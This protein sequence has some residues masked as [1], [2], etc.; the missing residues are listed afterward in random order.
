MANTIKIDEFFDLDRL[1]DQQAEAIKLVND[2]ISKV[3]EAN[4][5]GNIKMTGDAKTITDATKA[6]NENEQATRKQKETIDKTT[7]AYIRQKQIDDELLKTKKL[8]T[9]ATNDQIGAYSRLKAQAELAT[10]SARDLAAQYGVNS[11]QAKDAALKANDLNTKLKT[12]DSTMNI[13]NKN[14]GNYSSGIEGMI[15][16]FK[17]LAI[18]GVAVAAVVKMIGFA[19]DI[20]K[21]AVATTETAM[22]EFQ[23]TMTGMDKAT[24]AFF[25]TIY[26]G[27][28]SNLLDNMAEAY[29][30]G[31]EYAET[32]D[33]IAHQ[34]A[35]N[36]ANLGLESKAIA[37]LEEKMK[38]K[39]LNDSERLQ[40]AKDLLILKK[41]Y[42]DNEITLSAKTL[43]AQLKLMKLDEQTARTYVTT[44][45]QNLGLRKQAENYN[46]LLDE[47]NKLLDSQ[48]QYQ[49]KANIVTS[50]GTVIVRT[51]QTKLINENKEALSKYSQEIIAFAD[52]IRKVESNSP[53]NVKLLVQAL[54]KRGQSEAALYNE[55]KR[56]VTQTHAL[57]QSIEDDRKKA[58]EAYIK[59]LEDKRK[60]EQEY[61]KDLKINRRETVYMTD[62]VKAQVDAYTDL[63]KKIDWAKRN[64]LEIPI[65]EYD[66][67]LIKATGKSIEELTAEYEKLFGSIKTGKGETFLEWWG[68]LTDPEKI[69]TI[70][71][72]VGQLSGALSDVQAA[73]DNANQQELNDYKVLQDEKTRI[74]NERLRLGFLSQEQYNAELSNLQLD[75][76]EKKR[77]LEEKEFKRK[78]AV[79]LAEAVIE[80]SLAV[81]KIY[82][83]GTGG[84]LLK[85]IQAGLIAIQLAAQIANITSQVPTYAKG[86]KD[87][88]AETAIVGEQGFEYISTDTGLFK[89]PNRATMTYLPAGASVIPHNKSVQIE[90]YL[91]APG[92]NGMK[93]KNSIENKELLNAINKLNSKPNTSIN[94]DKHGFAVM[95]AKGGAYVNFVNDHIRIKH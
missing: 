24:K 5:S 73:M 65:E 60:K 89:T 22:D 41:Q 53:E 37:E 66:V 19:W 6:I 47:R 72:W 36:A 70:K 57:E 87:G 61:F 51:D 38:N 11:K 79:A 10:K 86:R 32:M 16:K 26:E 95:V 43:D 54:T 81:I 20:Y 77:A 88:P 71:D 59:R 2:Y 90:H 3:G 76:D 85:T 12:I 39:T 23:F 4:K 7:E 58:H 35:A 13:H 56:I 55:N 80:S 68:G 69:D 21:K 92:V 17:G 34:T 40:A 94:I 91:Q 74:L 64:N 52:V 83:Q 67:E 75:Y 82:S 25:K 49:E 62:E 50:R 15:E 30:R 93:E 8:E 44:D 84:Y 31:H 48:K 33:L 28:W 42:Y 9:A 45:A 78:K 29:K 14:V 46:K 18:A 1:K 63:F 27:D